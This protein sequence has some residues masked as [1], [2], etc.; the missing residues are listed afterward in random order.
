MADSLSSSKYKIYTITDGNTFSSL[1]QVRPALVSQL[2]TALQ[3]RHR[4]RSPDSSEQVTPANVMRCNETTTPPHP[5][6][7]IF[8]SP[9]SSSPC[10]QRALSIQNTRNHGS[11]PGKAAHLCASL[12][13]TTGKHIN[14]L[15]ANT[16]D[17]QYGAYHHNP[18]NFK[19][20]SF[21]VNYS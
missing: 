1:K 10:R 7:S 21:Q 5:S 15:I 18:V 3:P 17:A 16:N 9:F 12:P 4:L 14:Q 20:R 6:C 2:A 8:I 19:S 13:H 11:E